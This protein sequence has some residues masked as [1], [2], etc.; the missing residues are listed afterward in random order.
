MGYENYLFLKLIVYNGFF[1][2]IIFQKCMCG[3]H[4]YICVYMGIDICTCTGTHLGM[5]IWRPKFNVT[6]FPWSVSILVTEAKSYTWPYS[7]LIQMFW[8]ARLLQ[9]S[10]LYTFSTVRLQVVTMRTQHLCRCWRLLVL[11]HPSLCCCIYL[12]SNS[13]WTLYFI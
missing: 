3:G 6:S 13:M 9:G 5:H 4:V 8:I 7:L 12:F 10:T 2:F 1:K 11:L